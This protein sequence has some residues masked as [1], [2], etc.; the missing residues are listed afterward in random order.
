MDMNSLL[1]AIGST[2]KYSRQKGQ[3]KS[4]RSPD[5]VEQLQREAD[6]KRQR[7]RERNLAYKIG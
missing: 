5:L 1:R 7:R 3:E 4:R 2:T 6:E